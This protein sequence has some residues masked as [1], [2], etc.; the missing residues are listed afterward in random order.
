MFLPENYQPTQPSNGTYLRFKEG[1]T[2]FRILSKKA[3]TG[4]VYWNNQNKPVRVKEQPKTDR[5]E[6]IR[7]D[8]KGKPEKIK[9]FWV[10]VVYDY[11][12]ESVA[13]LEITQAT[14]QRAIH[15]LFQDSDWGHPNGYDIKVTRSGSGIDTDYQVS[16]VPHKAFDYSYAAGWEEID[17]ESLFQQSDPFNQDVRRKT[18]GESLREEK[19]NRFPSAVAPDHTSDFRLRPDVLDVKALGF[20]SSAQ[21]QKAWEK[22]AAINAEAKFMGLDLHPDPALTTLQQLTEIA[23]GV[24][25]AIEEAKA[26]IVF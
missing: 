18:S 20:S 23:K 4:Y 1:T 13:I 10:V 22:F 11:G 3:V 5:P 16:P 24:K 14:I 8:D 17:L 19:N 2:R 25:A 6:G 26:E 9:H 21:Y 12:S 15:A 7:F